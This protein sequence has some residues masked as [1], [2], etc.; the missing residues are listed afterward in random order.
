MSEDTGRE[1]VG[2]KLEI[3]LGW[4]RLSQGCVQLCLRWV[5][6]SRVLL[7]Y[8]RCRCCKIENR[9]VEGLRMDLG[10]SVTGEG[11]VILTTFWME[12]IAVI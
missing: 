2:T 3:G 7:G 1:M 8:V 9:C 4:L 6:I 11:A 5:G 10:K 12:K